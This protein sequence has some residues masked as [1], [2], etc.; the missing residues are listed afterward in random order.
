[1]ND[2]GPKKSIKLQSL[3]PLMNLMMEIEMAKNYRYRLFVTIQKRLLQ[4]RPLRSLAAY[5]KITP[6]LQLL[7]FA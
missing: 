1:M 4:S 6:N 3:V 7:K 5:L 2:W